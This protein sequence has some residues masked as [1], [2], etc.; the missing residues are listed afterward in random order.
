MSFWLKPYLSRFSIQCW[1]SS[2]SF[3]ASTWHCWP[4]SASCCWRC[5]QTGCR[6]LPANRRNRQNLQ[7]CCCKRLTGWLWH[8]WHGL[9]GTKDRLLFGHEVVPWLAPEIWGQ[10]QDVCDGKPLALTSETSGEALEVEVL[11]EMKVSN[12]SLL[13]HGDECGKLCKGESWSKVWNESRHGCGKGCNKYYEGD[14]EECRGDSFEGYH[15]L[16]LHRL[17]HAP[18]FMSG[19]K[20]H[21]HSRCG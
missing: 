7:S 14:S 1:R 5:G 17:F 18:V 16:R 9:C 10:L 2:C 21:L 19:D 8:R 3:T 15:C 11:E 4:F 13:S 6:L 20:L 12:V